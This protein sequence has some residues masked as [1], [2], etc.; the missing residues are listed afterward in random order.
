[1][2]APSCSPDPSCRIPPA[3]QRQVYRYDRLAHVPPASADPPRGRASPPFQTR[4]AAAF[5]PTGSSHHAACQRPAVLL[6]RSAAGRR[7][8]SSPPL[9]GAGGSVPARSA[10]LK[11]ALQSACRPAA[12][13]S[14][15]R[16]ATETR[17]VTM[18][19]VANPTATIANQIVP[20]IGRWSSVARSAAGLPA[21]PGCFAPFAPSVAAV[22]PPHAAASP[23]ASAPGS[24]VADC[25]VDLPALPAAWPA[26]RVSLA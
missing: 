12:V 21:A 5:L 3:D 9:P 1:G 19:S 23:A 7:C 20:K 15:T 11:I 22:V 4:A 25:A 8:A 6:R 13:L 14:E 16:P 24:S 10:D 18:R 2:D 17:P 26:H